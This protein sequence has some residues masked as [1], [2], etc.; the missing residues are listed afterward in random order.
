MPQYNVLITGAGNGFGR[1]VA[2]RLAEKGW[3]K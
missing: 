3:V 2:F 1:E